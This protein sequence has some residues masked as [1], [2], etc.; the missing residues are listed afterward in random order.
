[1]Q[2]KLE[3]FTLTNPPTLVLHLMVGQGYPG[4]PPL[5]DSCSLCPWLHIQIIGQARKAR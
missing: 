5:S 4:V 1:M 2:S 3:C